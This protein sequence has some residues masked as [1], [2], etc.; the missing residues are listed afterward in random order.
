MDELIITSR[1][2]LAALTVGQ[3][4]SL[5]REGLQDEAQQRADTEYVYGIVGIARL[6]GVSRATAQRY[7]DTF[8][9]PAILQC[10][11]KIVANKSEVLDL[12]AKNN[13]GAER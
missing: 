2:P 6:L 8:L 3:F 5:M 12:F 10:G 13:G 4:L 9:K 11:R 7:K 1:T